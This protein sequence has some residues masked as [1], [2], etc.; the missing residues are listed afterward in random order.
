V[1]WQVAVKHLQ[2]IVD[3]CCHTAVGSILSTSQ[4]QKMLS[5][6]RCG[7]AGQSGRKASTIA[8][9]GGQRAPGRGIDGRACEQRVQ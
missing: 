6:P 8:S 7:A 2:C 1:A 3:I 4:A 9:D 5:G